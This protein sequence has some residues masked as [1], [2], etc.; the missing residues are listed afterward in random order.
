MKTPFTEDQK[1]KA[2]TIGAG[3]A[4]IGF[5]IGFAI[6]FMMGKSTRKKLE[7]KVFKLEGWQ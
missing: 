3:C 2:F 6:A 4:L 7:A 1:K 5:G